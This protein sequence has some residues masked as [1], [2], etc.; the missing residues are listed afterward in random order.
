MVDRIGKGAMG[1]VYAA[2]DEQLGRRVAVKLMLADFEEEPELRERFYREARITGQLAHRN[3]VTVFDLGEDDGRP[4]I[5]MELLDGMPLAD[6]L[7]TAAA[8]SI[9]EKLDLMMQICD[10]LQNAHEAGV[11]H[12]D[13]KPS[14]LFVFR[15]GTLKMLDFGVARLAA[16]NLTASGMLLGT[17]EYMSPEQARGQKMDARS[18]VFSAAGVFYFMLTGRPPFGSRDLRKML[19]AIINEPP[20]PLTDDEAPEA[21]R[22]ILIKALA[23]APDDRYQQCAEMRDD[24]GQVRRSNASATIRS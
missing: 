3:I 6:Y 13:V 7:G 14:N 22:R 18:D 8:S 2:M 21:L 19:H 20:V 24:L 12:R 16:S 5:V 1:V 10:G 11:V 23:K 15:D 9:D 17:P 4:F